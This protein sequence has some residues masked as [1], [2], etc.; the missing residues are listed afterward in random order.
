M[1]V[2][3]GRTRAQ[4]R[5]S[6]GF[7]LGAIKTGTATGGT[8]NTLIDVNT[9][10]GGDDNYNGK[11][12]IVTDAS[13]GTTQTTQYVNDY[14]SSNNTI[15]FQQNA[16]FTVASGDTYEIWD[17]I[18][19]PDTIN[20]F[21][22]QSILDATGAVYDPIENTSLHSDGKSL[23]FAVPDNIAMIQNIYYSNSVDFTRLHACNTAFDEQS[24]LVVT[25]LNGAITDASATTVTVTSAS[26]LRAEQLIMVGSEKMTISSI[27]SN[28]LTVGRG[29]G[30]TTAAT[31]SDGVSVLLF[32]IVITESKKQGTGSNQFIIPAGASA[33]QI[34]TDSITS[35]DISK[36]NYLEGWVKITRSS[37]TA[38]SAG[39]LSI[40][41]DDTANCA[42]PL[43]TVNLPALTDDTWTFFRV[44]L[45]NP[46]L[47]TAI[48]S[49]GLKYDVDLG[50]CT[51]WLDD[52][53]VTRND[54]GYWRQVPRNLWRIDKQSR[55][56]V[57]DEYFDGFAPYSLLKIVGGDKPALLSSDSTTNEI[58]DSYI[59]ERSTALAFSAS[60]GG[61]N[62]D[63]DA[64]RQQ[65][66]FWFGMAQA[67]KRNF[68]LL[69]NVRTVD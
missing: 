50:A 40:L 62:T 17:S 66:A 6:I 22:N 59:T 8:N 69:T 35:K 48:I 11:I 34:V 60:S 63:P 18:Y 23:R 58:S 10:R 44:A 4:L 1:A 56:I 46:E 54:T 20:E 36:Y 9:F 16:S 57:F 55:D 27:S 5:Q 53:S 41:L 3:Q 25:T 24:T 21:I 12:V 2:V 49:V 29:A 38:T 43:E 33:D 31:H 15:Q 30:G 52:L 13:D 45:T 26:S 51:V 7:N 37:G 32:P 61:P 47:N 64:R 39:D 67:S 65:A 19:N 68:P 28:T 14:T 42:S